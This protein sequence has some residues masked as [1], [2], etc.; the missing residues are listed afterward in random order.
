MSLVEISNDYSAAIVL[1]IQEV[2]KTK[3]EID[4]LRTQFEEATSKL[5][6]MACKCNKACAPT[7][8]PTGTHAHTHIHT[9]THT[10]S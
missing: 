10:G 7:H 6:V 2:G 4:S 9:H 5:Q 8:P 3:L 1:F